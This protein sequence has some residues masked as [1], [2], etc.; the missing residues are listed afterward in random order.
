MNYVF[1]FLLSCKV[2]AFVGTSNNEY[3]SIVPTSH[4]LH[5]NNSCLFGG[6]YTKCHNYV[7]KCFLD[8]E[9]NN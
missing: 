4:M 3:L 1:I 5:G 8:M 7:G 9:F 2:F 6:F